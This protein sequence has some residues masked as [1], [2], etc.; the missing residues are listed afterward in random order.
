MRQRGLIVAAEKVV[1]WRKVDGENLAGF[2][3]DLQRTRPPAG[4]ESGG[5]GS[6]AA[7]VGW[8]EQPVPGSAGVFPR[9]LLVTG[10]RMV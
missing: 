5:T 7:K 6:G 10:G 8:F 1:S 4:S 2:L 9:V 3:H